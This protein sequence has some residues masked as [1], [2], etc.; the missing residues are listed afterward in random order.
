[1]PDDV[2]G[3][4]P[5]TDS[6]PRRKDARGGGRFNFAIDFAAESRSDRDGGDRPFTPTEGVE[7]AHALEL[8]AES[9]RLYAECGGARGEVRSPRGRRLLQLIEMLDCAAVVV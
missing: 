8:R 3:N 4:P 5:G 7:G 9:I 1:M 2:S 6:G